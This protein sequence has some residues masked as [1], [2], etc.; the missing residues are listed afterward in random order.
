MVSGYPAGIRELS[1]EQLTSALQKGMGPASPAEQLSA[2]HGIICSTEYNISHVP[3]I[4]RGA[5]INTRYSTVFFIR[6][7]LFYF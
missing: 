6:F 5:K 7:F 3:V 1:M 4:R 2:S